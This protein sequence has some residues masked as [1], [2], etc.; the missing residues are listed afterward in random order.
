MKGSRGL[1]V[2]RLQCLDSVVQQKELQINEK[3]GTT[4]RYP[5]IAAGRGRPH[6]QVL[7]VPQVHKHIQQ[8]STSINKQ[9]AN[10]SSVF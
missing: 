10:T 5:T 7:V 8:A 1:S 2:Q 3:N 6:M 9:S 4:L